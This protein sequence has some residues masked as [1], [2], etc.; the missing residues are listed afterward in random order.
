[1]LRT[2]MTLSSAILALLALAGPSAAGEITGDYLETRT[3]DVYTG[4]CFANSQVGLTGK[5][6]ILAWSIDSGSYR[7][8]DLTG[9]KVVAAVKAADTLGFGGGLV[10]RPDPIKSV[11][12]V[13]ERATPEQR[14]AL[15][16]FAKERAGRVLG[17]VI[18]VEATP[19]NMSV[20]HADMIAKLA[21][22]K[23]VRV[24]TRM[25]GASDCV[26]TNEQIFYPPL[27]K[28]ANSAPAFTVTGSYTGR[29][30]GTKWE[31]PL[32]RSAFLATF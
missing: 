8:V 23:T 5:E 22:G 18:R 12:L 6:A 1:M 11:L 19:I 16:E 31:S 17:S 9:L 2:I 20:N 32:T 24:E 28:V 13:D 10:I 27:T 21:A 15:V 4:P 30:L 29:G 3:C 14:E 7:G 26:C 25:L